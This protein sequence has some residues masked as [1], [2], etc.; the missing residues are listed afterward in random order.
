MARTV[1][2]AGTESTTSPSVP[3]P[4]ETVL[5]IVSYIGCGLSILGLLGTLIT[6]A[7]FR[8]VQSILSL[9]IYSRIRTD[10]YSQFSELPEWAIKLLERERFTKL[11]TSIYCVHVSGAVLNGRRWRIAVFYSPIQDACTCYMYVDWFCRQRHADVVKCLDIACVW[12]FHCLPVFGCTPPV[13]SKL[14]GDNHQR[15]L[16]GLCSTLL[17][18]LVLFVAG[19][20][21]TSNRAACRTVAILMHYFLLSAFMWMSAEATVLYILLVKV[22]GVRLESSMKF[23]YL[24]IFSES[25][26]LLL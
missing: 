19:I 26:V 24:M 20:S 7:I 8:Y 3:T 21:A 25:H 16:F 12:K 22:F 14:R 11:L 5:S 23:I 10:N 4:A 1:P 13:R 15:L 2:V 18:V 6:I 9:E 17:I